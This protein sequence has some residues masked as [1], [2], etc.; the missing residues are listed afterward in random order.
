MVWNGMH[1]AKR[2]NPHIK[3]HFTMIDKGK[4]TA[5]EKLILK[6]AYLQSNRDRNIQIIETYEQDD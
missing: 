3:D 1:R 5:E 2:L 6:R 4:F